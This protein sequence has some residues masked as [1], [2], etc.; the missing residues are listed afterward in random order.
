MI[1]IVS[2][3]PGHGKTLFTL[4]ETHKHFVLELGRSVFYHGVKDLT[5]PGW[6]ELESA[7]AWASAPDGAVIVI[8]EASIAFRA[9]AT[10][11]VVP[12]HQQ[13]LATHR[14]HGHD[15]ILIC[16]H[17]HQLSTF[18]RK[19]AERH[20]DYNRIGGGQRVT[21]REWPRIANPSNDKDREE[22]RSSTI[23]LDAEYFSVYTSAEVH[24][25]EGYKWGRL[26]LPGV[27][28]VCVALGLGYF[29]W[30]RVHYGLGGGPPKVTDEGEAAPTAPGGGNPLAPASG[31]AVP[32]GA[33]WGDVAAFTP[34]KSGVPWSAPAY[35]QVRPVVDYPRPQCMLWES[36]DRVGQCR[37]YSQQGTLLAV[38]ASVCYEAV[39]RGWWDPSHKRSAQVSAAGSSEAGRNGAAV[40]PASDEPVQPRWGPQ[41]YSGVVR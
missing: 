34:R 41:T 37:C 21:R 12:E 36:G 29:G 33:T 7:E 28:L 19:L 23:K 32:R 4:Q 6:V 20:I 18:T 17:P 2:G 5:L 24:T 30:S 11:A 8:D 26:M 31:L 38:D 27:V 25:V 39:R 35:D 14:H 15:I 9:L 1:T 13:A 10:G 40:G 22:S 3:R 16:Q